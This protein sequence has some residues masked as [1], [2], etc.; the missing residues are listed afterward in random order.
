MNYLTGSRAINC[1]Y[2]NFRSH[3]L[4]GKSKPKESDWDLI[5]EGQELKGVE[6]APEGLCNQEICDKYASDLIV[7]TPTGPARVINPLGMMLMKRSH[8]H[9]PIDFEKHIRDYHFLKTRLSDQIDDDYL[10]LLAKRTAETKLKYGD[11]HPSLKQGKK[12]FFDDYV[13]KKYEHDDIHYATCYYNEPIYERLKLDKDTVFCQRDLWE[14]LSHED[15]IRCVRE[16]AFVIAIERKLIPKPKFPP[17]FAFGWALF[18]I[19]TT[20][21]SGWF[22]DFAIENWVEI[23]NHNCDFVQKFLNN[24][25]ELG[26]NNDT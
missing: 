26:I 18:R 6:Y 15:Q 16:E 14:K 20:L 11:K 2:P 5:G 4:Y 7:D 9:R 10:S 13:S 3:E 8:L 17:S 12:E 23:K 25:F 24:G 19:C 22:R 1:F 21:T